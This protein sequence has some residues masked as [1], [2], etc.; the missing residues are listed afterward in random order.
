MLFSPIGEVLQYVLQIMF[1]LSNNTAEY[2]AALHGL[3]IAVSFEIKRLLVR[4]NLALVI[5]KVNKDWDQNS[6]KMDP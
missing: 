2:E 5:N 4:E 6:K 3:R 1:P